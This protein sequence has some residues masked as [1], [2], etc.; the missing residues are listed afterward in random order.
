MSAGSGA[1]C[2]GT[3][4]GAAGGCCCRAEVGTV[5]HAALRV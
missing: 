2:V 3:A 1:V 4:M 5:C